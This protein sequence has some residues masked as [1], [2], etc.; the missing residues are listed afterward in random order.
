MAACWITF[1]LFLWRPF[2][3]LIRQLKKRFMAKSKRDFR[4]LD[5]PPS[6]YYP[7]FLSKEV[8][9]FVIVVT[10]SIISPLILPFGLVY[11]LVS[12]FACRYNL[13]YVF[14]QPWESGGKL[15]SNM[16]HQMLFGLVLCQATLVGVFSLQ[17]FIAGAVVSALLIIP[18]I[19]FWVWCHKR[20]ESV[21]THGSLEEK[22]NGEGTLETRFLK[23]NVDPVNGTKADYIH[24]V[25]HELE[26][27]ELQDGSDV[28]V[29]M[30]R[31]KLAATTSEI[32]ID[33]RNV[34]QPFK[35]AK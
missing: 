11:F 19:I 33:Q 9:V 1:G 7:Y 26:M 16:F 34:Q 24:P 6:F 15:W 23:G 12:F 20:L 4:R 10:Y 30:P 25:F 28:E 29:N 35:P 22:M 27:P 3:V 8:L 18:T 17:Y 21:A 14:E 31:P 5:A 13:I 2:D 32:A